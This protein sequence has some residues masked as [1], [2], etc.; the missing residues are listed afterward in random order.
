MAAPRART[1][2][3]DD[4]AA[5][6]DDVDGGECAA[7]MVGLMLVRSGRWGRL[8]DAAVAVAVAV[9]VGVGV[10]VDVELEADVGIEDRRGGALLFA[11]RVA[12]GVSSSSSCMW[13]C[14]RVC[15]ALLVVCSCVLCVCVCVRVLCGVC[16]PASSSSI[17][18]SASVRSTSMGRAGGDGTDNG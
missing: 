4:D 8:A 9:A 14:A 2:G 3:V 16:A 18:S 6:A 1:A 11:A 17:T 15:A 7:E 13:M 10:G 12:S 5:A